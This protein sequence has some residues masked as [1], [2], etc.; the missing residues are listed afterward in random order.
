MTIEDWLKKNTSTI[1]TCLGAG[2][3]VA[4]VALAIKATPKALDK[5]QCAQVDKGEEILHKLREGALEKSDTGYILPKLTAIETLQACWKEYLPTIAVGTGSLICIFGANVLSRRQQASLASAYAALESAYQ[6]YRRKVCS[7]LGPDTDAMIEKAVEQEKQD[8]EDD[9]P[10]WDEVQTFYLPCCGKAAFFERTMEE[11]VQA[12][13]HINRNL[14]LRGE[15][16]MNEFLSFLGLDAVEEGDVIGWDCYIGETQYGYRWI[17]F[18]HRHY[19]TD[20][21]LTVCSIDTP[22]APHSLD[23]LEYDGEDRVPTCGVD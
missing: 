2:G 17:D 7:I 11:V 22:F 13:Y 10:P 14:V 23:D 6:G 15:V 3:V 18:N 21:G 20:D 16:T 8:I 19:V 9:L 12:E 5:I 1:L 4:T